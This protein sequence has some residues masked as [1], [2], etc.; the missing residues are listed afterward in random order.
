MLVTIKIY[1]ALTDFD[2]G[3]KKTKLLAFR[4]ILYNILFFF[5]KK[6]TVIEA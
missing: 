1:F 2:N 6:L 5:L 3:F 4:K